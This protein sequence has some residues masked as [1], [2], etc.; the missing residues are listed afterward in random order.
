MDTLVPGMIATHG[1]LSDRLAMAAAARPDATHPRDRFPATDTFLASASRHNAA[2]NE[3][4][5][6]AVRHDLPDGHRRSREFTHQSKQLEIALA[7]VKA[8]LYGSTYSIRRPWDEVWAEVEREFDRTWQLER[9][10]VTE[11]AAT[12]ADPS[13]GDRLYQAELKAPTRPHPYVPHQGVR[14]RVARRVARQV[15]RFWDTTE[16]RMVPEPV[17]PHDRSHDGKLAQY[18]LADPHLPED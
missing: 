10:L 6:P 7:Q 16:G 15:D 12:G 1:V 11:L 13:L 9:A 18:L 14:G 2:V 3:V 8:K 17:K 4:L 5:V